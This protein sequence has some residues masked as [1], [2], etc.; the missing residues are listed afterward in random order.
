MLQQGIRLGF[1][2]LGL[3]TLLSLEFAAPHHAPTTP[4]ARRWLTNLTLA[5]INGGIVSI[6][7]MACFFLADQGAAP[8]RYGVFQQLHVPVWL[9]FGVEVL[10]LDLL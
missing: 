1:F 5:M 6:L 10:V 3:F 7:C 8:W 4:R 9:R 2:L